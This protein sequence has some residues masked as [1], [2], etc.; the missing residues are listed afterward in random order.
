MVDIRRGDIV[1]ADLDGPTETRGHEIRKKRPA[2]VIQNDIGNEASATTI[3]APTS[4][5]SSPYPFQVNVT[6]ATSDFETDSY[7]MLDQ[8]RTVDIDER[9]LET[10]GSLDTQTMT[11]VDR[12]IEISLGLRTTDD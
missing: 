7:V 9:I 10:F 11:E 2:I 12:A 8:I 6:A 1:Y 4:S 5:G 3:I